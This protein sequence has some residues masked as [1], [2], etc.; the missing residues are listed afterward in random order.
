MT[1]NNHEWPGIVVNGCLCLTGFHL[2]TPNS[3]IFCVCHANFRLFVCQFII[4]PL[5]WLFRQNLYIP[6]FVF[7]FLDIPPCFLYFLFA[8]PPPGLFLCLFYLS[9]FSV[10]FGFSNCSTRFSASH[11]L[12]LPFQSRL[13][14]FARLY[15][16]FSTARLSLFVLY[17]FTTTI[18]PHTNFWN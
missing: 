9:G 13:P 15:L 10:C 17:L 6:T 14:L 16:Q 1:R 4:P 11:N 7:T 5:F 12:L 18:Q 2:Y 8:R 3:H